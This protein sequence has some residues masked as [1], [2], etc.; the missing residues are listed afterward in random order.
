MPGYQTYFKYK[1]SHCVK[2][3]HRVPSTR[4]RVVKLV[5]EVV[6]GFIDQVL[7]CLVSHHAPNSLES[8]NLSFVQAETT[9]FNANQQVWFGPGCLEIKDLYLLELHQCGST[10]EII[11]GAKQLALCSYTTMMR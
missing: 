1:Y 9:T 11:L 2:H 10:V 7:H 4:A 8:H 6:Q 5:A 3:G